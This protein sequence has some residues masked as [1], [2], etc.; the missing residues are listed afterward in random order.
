MR[1]RP[2]TP[3][4]KL[5]PAAVTCGDG[6]SQHA[7]SYNY[8][9][10]R[11]ASPNVAQPIARPSFDEQVYQHRSRLLN[12]T[13]A[14]V[15]TR[16]SEVR[17]PRGFGTAY[18][19]RVALPPVSTPTSPR[20]AGSP[21]DLLVADASS[22]TS[23]M[24]LHAADLPSSPAAQSP[25]IRSIATS[26]MSVPMRL[27]EGSIQAAAR[28]SPELLADSQSFRPI[29]ASPEVARSRAVISGTRSAPPSST[30]PGGVCRPTDLLAATLL[31]AAAAEGERP[32]P[33]MGGE[34]TPPAI[35]CAGSSSGSSGSSGGGIASCDAAE[36][37]LA[38]VEAAVVAANGSSAGNGGTP[39][40]GKVLAARAR[41]IEARAH[42]QSL[43][44][45]VQNSL[46]ALKGQLEGDV[47]AAFAAQ[48]LMWA[49]PSHGATPAS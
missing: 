1:R 11:R 47:Q 38:R 8:D 44:S 40:R 9:F 16:L 23:T 49:P 12:E 7:S 35:A 42:L 33:T 41:L 28:E 37:A 3:R 43:R 5:S 31:S 19:P 36:A 27:T 48:G 34:A 4:S 13:E 25:M 32:A 45:E 2:A 6:L 10:P 39:A 15:V 30:A 20:R 14:R 24:R 29:A 17:S 22:P 46:S 21:R 18:T 26:S